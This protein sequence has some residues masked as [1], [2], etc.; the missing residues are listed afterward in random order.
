MPYIHGNMDNINASD[1][2]AHAL[3]HYW[4]MNFILAN[5]D[6]DPRSS[7]VHILDYVSK[8]LL[9]MLFVEEQGN[10][11]VFLSKERSFQEYM[12]THF[13]HIKFLKHT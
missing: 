9:Y 13:P 4:F 2:Q 7:N 5:R 10:E 1:D 8:E 12:R 3:T 6:Q 11:R